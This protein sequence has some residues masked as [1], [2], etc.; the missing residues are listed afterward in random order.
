MRKMKLKKL[1]AVLL[2]ACML[3]G[4]VP[5]MASAASVTYTIT[6]IAGTS[7]AGYSGDGG[8][9][10]SAQLNYSQGVAVD[11]SG[12]I[13]IADQSNHRVRKVDTSGNISTVAG[14]GTPG[15]SGDGGLATSAQLWQ[16][17][18][19]AVD[20]SGNIYIAD[21]TNNR[22]R[23]VDASGNISTVAGTGTP[24]YSGDGGLATSAQLWQPSGV[25][26]DSSGNIYI[27]DYTNNRV[28]KVDASGNISTVAGTGVAGY[29]G[30]G[31]LATSAQLKNPNGLA[32]DSSGNIFI[33]DQ[34]NNRVRKVDASGNISTVAGTGTQGYSGD[35]G[36]ATSAQLNYPSGVA[37]DSSGNI[38]IPDY[39]NHR[40]RKVDAS[41]NISTVAGTG[42]SGYAGDGGLA[43]SAQLNHPI[44]VAVDSSG[45][46]YI[47]DYTNSRIRKLTDS[48][49]HTVTYDG[50][51]S[52]GGSVPADSNIY[53]QDAKVT[54]LGNT[55]SLTKTGYA[56]VGWNTA[57]D[58]SGTDYVATSTLKMGT[59]NLVLYAR[60]VPVIA[61]TTGDGSSGSPYQIANLGNLLWLSHNNTANSGFSGKYF[62]QT[63]NIDISGI[64][65]WTPIGDGTTRFYG[66]Y[67]GAGFSVNGL[68]ISGVA[69]Q[70]QGLFGYNAGTIKNLGVTNVT[71]NENIAGATCVGALAGSSSG[72]VTG[73][74]S[75]GSII[76]MSHYGGLIGY[77]GAGT[78]S[79]SFSTCTMSGSSGVG[80]GFVGYINNTGTVIYNCYSSGDY[81]PSGNGGLF[82]GFIYKE[83]TVT[84]CFT[85]GTNYGGTSIGTVCGRNQG[86]LIKTYSAASGSAVITVDGGS[87]NDA[88]SNKG[89]SFFKST[90][91][92]NNSNYSSSYPWDFTNIWAID[93]SGTI[94]SGFPYLRSSQLALASY[95]V[96]FNSNDGSTVAEQ[97]IVS[98]SKAS[99]P[100]EPTKT[101]YVF[102]GW[103]TDN[104]TF[105]NAFD[106]ATS[107]TGDIT[108]YAKWTSDTTAPIV[109]GVADGGIY[110]SSRTITF[111]EGTATLNG[112]GFTSGSTVS[113]ENTYTLVVTDSAGNATTVHFTIDKTA[114]VISG[115]T[116]G[117]AYNGGAAPTFTG[118]TGMLDG[119]GYTSGTNIIAACVHTLIVSDTAGNTATVNF[120]VTQ[121]KPV[122]TGTL[123]GGIYNTA[124]TITVSDG[125]A[126][127]S[128]DGALAQAFTSGSSVSDDGTYVLTATNV[129]GTTTVHFIIDKTAPTVSGVT[130]GGVYAT[131]ATVTFSDAVTTPTATLAMNG[132]AASAFTSGTNVSAVGTY[133][134]V[135]SDQAGNSATVNFTVT[136]LPPVVSGVMNNGLYN[137][138]RT[139]SFNSGTA[140]LDN[141]GG[142]ASFTSGNTVSSEGSYTLAVTNPGGTT[143]MHFTIDKTLP[144]ITGVSDSGIYA[145]TLTIS[146]SDNLAVTSATMDG[147]AFTS[148]NSIATVGSHIL[149]VTDTAGNSRTVNFAIDNNPPVVLGVTEGASYNNSVTISFDSGTATIV[150]DGGAA[151]AFTSGT[152]VNADG[153]YTL[154]VT[155][156]TGVTTTR[157]FIIDTVVPNVTGITNGT[158][159]V[160]TVTPA[161]I[162]DRLG[163]TATLDGASFT[164]GTEV[165]AQGSHTLVVTDAAGNTTTVN[166]VVTPPVPEID[167]VTDGGIYNHDVVVTFTSGTATLDGISGFVSGT[168]VTD[169]V[170]NTHTL[171]VDNGTSVTVHFTIDKT[172][173]T[174]TGVSD[175]GVYSG[176]RLITYTDSVTAA[177]TSASISKDGGTAVAFSKNTTV[178]DDGSYVLIVTDGAGNTTTVNF[179]IDK[180]APS[181]SG[182]VDGGKYN[183]SV[184]ISYNKGT[185]TLDGSSF[186]SGNSVSAEGSHTL[187]ATNAAGVSTTINFTIDSTAPVVTGVSNGGSY[188]LGGG[189]VIISYSDAMSTP[190]ATLSKNGIAAIAFASGSSVTST[191]NYV[192][193]VTDE[194]G[195]STTINFTVTSNAPVVSGV[196]DGGKYNTNR[197]IS[198]NNGSAT[199]AKDG[200]AAN[201]FTSGTQVT[202]EGSYILAVT[203][204]AG[205]TT[206]HFNIDKLAP[207]VT[208]VADQGS[209]D[210]S[211]GN[212]TI[213]YSDAVTTP[214]ATLSK[215][216]GVAIAFASGS[217]VTIPGNYLLVVTD[218]VGNSTVVNFTVTNNPP[219]VSGVV[220]SGKYN[221]NRTISFS[222]GSAT[223]DNGGGAVA[224]TSGS[225]VTAEG[226]YTLAVTN[227][228]GTTTVNFTIDKTAP[229][230]SGVTDSSSYDN[231]V[232]V[233]FNEGTAELDGNPFVAGTVAT[234]GAHILVVT[235]SA[236]NS[237]TVNFTITNAAPTV[238]GVTE[239]GSYNTDKTI[240]FSSGT[241]TLNNGSGANSFSDGDVVSTEGNYTLAVTNGN[242]ATTVHFIIDKTAP[243]VSGVANGGTYTS[244]VVITYSD[245]LST[246]TATLDGSSFASGGT[247]TGNGSHTLIL[248][249]VAGNSVTVSFTI[250]IASD[251]SISPITASFDKK[252]SA[253][254]DIP[255]TVTLNGNT[256][257][258]IAN[259][260][261]PLV[262]GTDY[263]VSGNVYSV[264]KEYMAAQ[265]AGTTSLTFNFGVGNPQTLTVTVIDTTS[266]G[267]VNYPSSPQNGINVIVN[268]QTQS[269]AATATTGVNTNGQ[270]QTTVT[271]DEGKMNAILNKLPNADG[272]SGTTAQP[273]VIQIPVTANTDSVLGVLTGQMVK[274]MAKKDV[275][276]EIK[277]DTATYTI[278]A[279]QIKIDAV[280][281]QLG[282]DVKLSDIKVQIEIAKT[283]S[284]TVKVVEDSALKGNFTIVVPPVNFN[285]TC[286]YSG[287]TVEVSQFNS[288]VERTVAIPD[289]V[290]PAKITTG[291]I[292]DP[293]GIARHVPTKITLVNGKNYAQIRSLTNSTY[294]VVYH[295]VAFKDVTNHWAKA[296]VNDMGSRLVISGVGNDMFEPDRDITRA[297][298]AAIVVRAL[299]LKPGTGSNPF[300]DVSNTAWYCDYVKTAAEY[301]L[302]SGYGNGKF[303]PD[304]KITREQ[305]MTMIA[306]AMK[307]TGLDTGLSGTEA[308]A[309]LS[310]YKDSSGAS[311]YA[312]DG[313]AT[314]LKTGIITGRTTDTIC[315]IDNITRAEVAVIVQRLLQKSGLI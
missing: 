51:G 315:P 49:P 165:T 95:K 97:T 48:N 251:S 83:N 77:I 283:D 143:T 7:T 79:N 217:S 223:L 126:T 196:A 138:D 34:T 278:P 46:I 63:A 164:S 210:L 257:T 308:S 153:S 221:T 160:S 227:G 233:S 8:L 88:T 132:G 186:N 247:A 214:T 180:T 310:T 176:D 190:T 311:A 267:G 25:A 195:N 104:T 193:V 289:G 288:Y 136:G 280:S 213:N 232:A 169:A 23:K 91:N 117:G 35:G 274:D 110:N 197:T 238:T 158:S 33:S 259:G 141:G 113:A 6:T 167:G 182:V 60:W 262:L 162:D 290:D 301:N 188:D 183:Q 37:V 245:A 292:I 216:G 86:T 31:G 282:Q 171:V 281:Q 177:N 129:A 270:S 56:F 90:S 39:G 139:I 133:T 297:E 155:K 38:F 312:K 166:F 92:F 128:K 222:N 29:S 269:G 82:A 74:Y 172:A 151:T 178:T 145:G 287:K 170:S 203:N 3:L 36:L 175:G 18:G 50:N 231:S 108:L 96:T 17:S 230:I 148:G 127:L 206:V 147:S 157:N 1:V 44:G 225:Q 55:G 240:H 66:S 142:P 198:F 209:Y 187:I 168:T 243:V 10:T 276:L 73:C 239:G 40:V 309:L 54:V 24:G 268:G 252:T 135:V 109:T 189:D 5:G 119:V 45:I 159:Y 202:G 27:A 59:S 194:A 89:A 106:F 205:T 84:N 94:N 11:N 47:S 248:T 184:T 204:G 67:D 296:A 275:T 303:G 300:T 294:A 62:L 87:V 218:E 235:D 140:T 105:N 101:G 64:S 121:N 69:S 116:E 254:A 237:T 229:V 295:P 265:A 71:I 70:N 226:S 120:T 2:T 208:G 154:V 102:S 14:T 286:T 112:T 85:T 134:L 52:T 306:R 19:V 28:R 41:G 81:Y 58:G 246:A 12:N 272:S 150:K 130:E 224:F 99:A 249:D 253:Q 118:G 131:G 201:A 314:C 244:N 242:G 68:S 302:I 215:D 228:A 284:G 152:E 161:F 277:T 75:T 57:D 149:V 191:G 76:G 236:G 305:A 307:I 107:I 125:T 4:V 211:N 260:G 111:N 179:I 53:I 273:P 61:P 200:G 173:P 185:A 123:D 174:V 20:S 42:A 114:P 241:A 16:P 263:T 72:T 192:L 98:G 103:Y 255:V 156:G 207:V 181:V 220:D 13:F 65:N 266:S 30:D 78:V 93:G 261:T 22:V 264:K 80:G 115:V 299:G 43:T 291:V 100:A 163:V 313:I 293:D 285:I 9:A 250:N 122:V 26:V 234:A 258:S 304:D 146:Y 32:V 199:L 271:V 256:F 219:V 279:E 124:K 21:Y 298:F 144:T 15:Y 212:V 137:T